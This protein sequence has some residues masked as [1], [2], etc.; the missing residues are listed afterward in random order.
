MKQQRK[1]EY[2]S[3]LRKV[4]DFNSLVI[5]VDTGAFN[6]L[7]SVIGSQETTDY[8]TEHDEKLAE[9]KNMAFN[10]RIMTKWFATLFDDTVASFKTDDVDVENADRDE[11]YHTVDE[12]RVEL[13]KKLWMLYEEVTTKIHH[14]DSKDDPIRPKM[15]R[16][17]F[18]HFA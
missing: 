16:K 11:A 9:G 2:V 4:P 17:Q 15:H 18:G 5:S 8:R 3:A 14:T 12:A 1:S 7:A 6:E 13:F 10:A